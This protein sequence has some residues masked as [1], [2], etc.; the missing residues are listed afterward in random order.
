MNKVTTF[1]L[2]LV[3]AIGT[4]VTPADVSY[5]QVRGHPP[6]TVGSAQSQPIKFG[7]DKTLTYKIG[8]H[9][10]RSNFRGIDPIG[11]IY[12]IRDGGFEL[13]GVLNGIQFDYSH[14]HGPDGKIAYD[15]LTLTKAD[16]RVIFHNLPPQSMDQDWAQIGDVVVML[17]SSGF[18][19]GHS[20]DKP[21]EKL[22]LKE[23]LHRTFKEWEAKLNIGAVK[24]EAERLKTPEP[25]LRKSLDVLVK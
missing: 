18:Y 2:G 23:R 13:G 3:G 17:D 14:S 10:P 20:S 4:V 19:E 8:E 12:Y 6:A 22:S 9:V 15:N 1:G 11:T 25:E 21:W 16:Y 7:L 5:A 24:A